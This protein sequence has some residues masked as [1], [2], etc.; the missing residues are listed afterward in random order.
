[1]DTHGCLGEAPFV[2]GYKGRTVQ[3]KMPGWGLLHCQNGEFFLALWSFRPVLS[4][5]DVA[6]PR[7]AGGLVPQGSARAKLVFHVDLQE[8]PCIL[9]VK[10]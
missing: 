1:M 5:G 4:A 7:D 9:G 10:V 8:T 2:S 3:E 6:F